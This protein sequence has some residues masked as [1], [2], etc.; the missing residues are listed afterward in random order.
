MS[1]LQTDCWSHKSFYPFPLQV[2]PIFPIDPLCTL[3]V[4]ECQST[5]FNSIRMSLLDYQ[6]GNHRFI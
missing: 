5:T 1:F 2:V 3:F 6:I 4:Q